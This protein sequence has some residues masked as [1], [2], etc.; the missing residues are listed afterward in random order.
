M[1]GTVGEWRSIQVSKVQKRSKVLLKAI[2]IGAVKAST[3]KGVPKGI[4]KAGGLLSGGGKAAISTL[5]RISAV[6]A[7][8]TMG[9][10]LV[11]SAPLDF[12]ILGWNI[13]KL[14]RKRQFE[15][16]TEAHFKREV[17]KEHCVAINSTVF[18]VGGA[19]VGSCIA[20]IIG[21]AVG[22]AAGSAIGEVVGR[23]ECLV[24]FR[25]ADRYFPERQVDMPPIVVYSYID[26]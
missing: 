6:G 17:V 1:A 26:C 16:I 10:A 13:S 20:P 5:T 21:T 12:G 19:L 2:A 23:V 4:T 8:H 3:L 25:I 9:L 7:S 15:L 18:G 22:A 11:T 24:T 14:Y